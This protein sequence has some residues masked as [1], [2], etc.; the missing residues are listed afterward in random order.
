MRGIQAKRC[1]RLVYGDRATNV[2]DYVKI[3][4]QLLTADKIHFWT[5]FTLLDKGCRGAYLEM[6]KQERRLSA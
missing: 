3:N 4:E 2:R 5:T 6:K 1:R